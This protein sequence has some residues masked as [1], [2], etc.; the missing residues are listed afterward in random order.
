VLRGNSTQCR[1]THL[2]ARRS[3]GSPWPACAGTQSEPV[4]TAVEKQRTIG[5]NAAFA[6]AIGV[7]LG[8]LGYCR[9]LMKQLTPK[10]VSVRVRWDDTFSSV[11]TL[12]TRASPTGRCSATNIASRCAAQIVKFNPDVHCWH[13]GKYGGPDP[14]HGYRC[15]DSGQKCG[16][17]VRGAWSVVRMLRRQCSCKSSV[18][19]VLLQRNILH[20]LHLSCVRLQTWTPGRGSSSSSSSSKSC[21]QAH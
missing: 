14:D 5:R 17:E 10:S 4:G 20:L 8:E 12:S 1:W 18:V 19:M 9:M 3:A 11:P 16:A 2:Q 13:V 21:G 7:S 6:A 15:C